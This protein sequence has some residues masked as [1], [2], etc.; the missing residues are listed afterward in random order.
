MELAFEAYLDLLEKCRQRANQTAIQTAVRFGDMTER[1]EDI[2]NAAKDT[3]QWIF[4]D[5]FQQVASSRHV[6]VLPFKN[7]LS[8]G[9]GIFHI[10]GKPGS[11]KST[12]MK[13]LCNHWRTKS[14]LEGWAGDKELVIGR[15]FFW[16]RG[17]K[18][19][20][21]LLG[22]IRGLTYCVVSQCPDIIAEI[23][24]QHW[25]PSRYDPWGHGL[26]VT[27]ENDDILQAFHRLVAV[28]NIYENYRFCFFIDGLDE[29]DESLQIH[30]GLVNSLVSWIETS[31][32]HLKICV[33]S[34]ELPVFQRRLSPNQRLRLQ[35][36]TKDDLASVIQQAIWQEQGVAEHDK[37][38]L[39]ILEIAILAKAD[40]VFLWV[41]LTLKMVCESLQSGESVADVLRILDT[42]P[43]ELE[44]FFRYIL[45]SITPALRRKAAFVFAFALGLERLPIAE[46]ARVQRGEEQLAMLSPS[47]FRY[48]FL[49]DFAD[50]ANFATRNYLVLEPGLVQ[51]RID[52]CRIRISGR[53]RGLLEFRPYGHGN[54]D[55][56]HQDIVK[57]TH[58]SI[59]EFLE[60]YMLK[61]WR[62]ALRG[63]DMVHAYTATLIAALKVSSIND[64]FAGRRII[65]RE[66]ICALQLVRAT[67]RTDN[68]LH[69]G[70]L[71]ML[72]KAIYLRWPARPTAV[73]HAAL[74]FHRYEYVTWRIHSDR[75]LVSKGNGNDAE[76]LILLI[77]GIEFHLLAPACWHTPSTPGDVL[78]TTL[79]ILNDGADPL[80]PSPYAN[81][82]F[83]TW[84]FLLTLI[85]KQGG[86][87]GYGPRYWAAVEAML[88]FTSALPQWLRASEHLIT[89]SIPAVAQI[90]EIRKDEF[91]DRDI[92]SADIP[93]QLKA[94]GG[95]ATLEDFIKHQTPEN[96]D[97]LLQIL[98]AKEE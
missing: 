45:D 39:K 35:D 83:S 14:A 46:W 89:L 27:L 95:T 52:S 62:E 82:N 15:F 70:H 50:D 53:C 37:A 9:D 24:P 30:S 36:L 73:F 76:A 79:C 29:F 92:D 81:E 11:G 75:S 32:G 19:Q 57:F 48:S 88:Q 56:G 63:F 13:F 44:V 87:K 17:S 66:L 65:D 84:S 21:N 67:G 42:M 90:F 77:R 20:K 61:H 26:V 47:L 3:F 12:L 97:R 38:G 64:N 28:E 33:S 54:S 85:S 34:R 68:L 1:Y 43:Q 94:V 71:H 96:S 23:F 16:S 10:S 51:D 4:D 86:R 5:S 2:A 78:Q 59:P 69:F 7:W 6:V 22:L 60:S 93:H 98:A 58:R 25:D 31:Q 8:N 41:V 80:S 55:E 91:M 74:S 18:M 40:G 49:D 72:E